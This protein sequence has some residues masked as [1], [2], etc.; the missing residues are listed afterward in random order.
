MT[1]NQ[2]SQ[3]G[4]NYGSF[5]DGFRTYYYRIPRK[6]DRRVSLLTS[7][8]FLRLNIFLGALMTT[9]FLCWLDITTPL[10]SFPE[11]L[12]QLSLIFSVFVVLALCVAFSPV[13]L[14]RDLTVHLTAPSHCL[15]NLVW[16]I[17]VVS[18]CIFWMGISWSSILG[19]GFIL[20]GVFVLML[21]VYCDEK[22][23]KPRS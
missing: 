6:I 3:Y 23:P 11:F 13:L 14:G 21:F 8:G 4:L 22:P 5:Q 10:D 1:T 2:G 12:L 15:R 7:I 17:C 19:N 9:F 16:A 20:G 18:I